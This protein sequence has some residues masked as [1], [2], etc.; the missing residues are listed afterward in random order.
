MTP[1]HQ[2]DHKI[3]CLY[4]V[5]HYIKTSAAHYTRFYEQCCSEIFLCF[6]QF[7]QSVETIQLLKREKKVWKGAVL[8]DLKIGPREISRLALT[9]VSS[10]S[11][12]H[13]IS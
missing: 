3:N 2:A 8:Q 5:D 7:I 4:F 11:L 9:A 10:R 13:F 6:V 12:I 1:I